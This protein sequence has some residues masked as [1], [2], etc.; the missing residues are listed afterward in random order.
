MDTA[1]VSPRQANPKVPRALAEVCLRLREKEPEERYA[2]AG[3][4]CEVLEELLSSADPEWDEPLLASPTVEE[5]LVAEPPPQHAE[6]KASRKRK[7]G[8]VVGVGLAACLGGAAWVATLAGTPAPVKPE[9]PAAALA[10]G[11]DGGQPP[12]A[13]E[14][15]EEASHKELKEAPSAAAVAPA[16][17]P[18][19]RGTTTGR[20]Q[21]AAADTPEKMLAS[22]RAP[23]EAAPST[24]VGARPA[25]ATPPKLEP[26]T[27]AVATATPRKEETTMKQPQPESDSKERET[28]MRSSAK[29]A[30]CT[31]AMFLAGACVGGPSL[32]RPPEGRECPSGS[33]EAM[34]KA[35]G[36]TAP[37]WGLGGVLGRDRWRREPVA[38]SDGESVL[39]TTT[40]PYQN[41]P[42]GSTLRGTV[43]LGAYESQPAAYFRFTQ[44]TG[45]NGKK[46]PVCMCAIAPV[47]SEGKVGPGLNVNPV[48]RFYE[49]C[50]VNLGFK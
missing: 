1:R 6:K 24:D 7:A 5:G 2:S 28:K 11:P 46:S 14:K 43:T 3:E 13:Q 12:V 33:I 36:I 37:D 23:P 25:T 17:A 27:A 18:R 21:Q 41:L 9:T 22:R 32:T 44:A 49:G 50:G 34:R 29:V 8:L 15:A 35:F 42:E 10:A 48:L 30:A 45:A 31:G 39:L 19:E 4:L 38:V 47:L 40:E 16:R 26:P 20:Q